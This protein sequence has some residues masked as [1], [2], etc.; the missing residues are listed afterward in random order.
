M[1]VESLASRE[2][3]CPLIENLDKKMK[4]LKSKSDDEFKVLTID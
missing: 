2:Y 3:C 4:E 1:E